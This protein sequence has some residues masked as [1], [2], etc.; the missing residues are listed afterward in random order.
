MYK[1][2]KERKKSESNYKKWN[3]SESKYMKWK[4]RKVKVSIRNKG[5]IK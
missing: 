5:L 3:E 2:R 1:I 4:E